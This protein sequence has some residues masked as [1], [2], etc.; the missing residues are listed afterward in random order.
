METS[1]HAVEAECYPLSRP[2]I[3]RLAFERKIPL[4]TT[5]SD[6]PFPA[7]A[8]RESEVLRAEATGNLLTTHEGREELLGE[9]EDLRVR[10]SEI[11]D[12]ALRQPSLLTTD[13]FRK[14]LKEHT[15]PLEKR[16]KVELFSEKTLSSWRGRGLLRSDERDRLNFHTAFAVMMMRL[17]DQRRER[18][19]LPPGQ[20]DREPYMY[21]WRQDTPQ[22]PAVPCGWPLADDIPNHT[23]LFTPWRALGEWGSSGWLSFADMGSVRWKGVRE[24]MGTLMWN[25]SE[26]DIAL[27]D[28]T[29]VPF[30][31]G[32][33]DSLL[34]LTRHTLA[35]MILLR[36]ASS[37]FQR[38]TVS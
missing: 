10:T 17:A 15:P 20:Y 28:S 2:M 5:Q 9:I 24:E 14:A 8:L 7:L 26:Q 35:T 34:P 19:F 38:T 18:G 37:V 30:G 25:L 1:A 3:V 27:W 13:W 21:V 6:A 33:V 22:S 29:I 36:Q 12:P 11:L 32:I 4:T 16:G 31:K 23:F